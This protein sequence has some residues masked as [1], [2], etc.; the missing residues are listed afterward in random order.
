MH[1]WTAH[2]DFNIQE[3]TDDIIDSIRY[4]QPSHKAFTANMKSIFKKLIKLD[5]PEIKRYLGYFSKEQIRAVLE[6]PE[7][8]EL[9]K[10]I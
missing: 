9:V 8:I 5:K 6:L 2:K 10:H 4:F 1:K 3:E 7:Y